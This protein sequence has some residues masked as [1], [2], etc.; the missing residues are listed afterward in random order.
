M[1][2]EKS[3]E[4][5]WRA[6]AHAQAFGETQIT[7]NTIDNALR[8]PGQYFDAET[9]LYQNYFRDYD[10][11]L[12]RYVQSDPTGLNGGLNY[13]SYVFANP[14]FFMDL[15]G[16]EVVGSWTVVP[17]MTQ[18]DF[19][20]ACVP[21]Y[22]QITCLA[23][24]SSGKLGWIG[25]QVSGEAFFSFGVECKDTCTNEEWEHS[26]NAQITASYNGMIPIPG[27]CGVLVKL[28]TGPVRS[29]W[30]KGRYADSMMWACRAAMA[31]HLHNG[32]KELKAVID[33]QIR[34]RGEDLVEHYLAEGPVKICMIGR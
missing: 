31:Y 26:S 7:L 32:W 12:G 2:F 11:R 27:M 8:F 17:H 15:L 23:P 9:G 20:F 13:Y 3:G 21:G 34:S 18:V 16:T 29:K 4:V 5:T 24:P 1:A 10:P 14:L 22:E 6:Q 30:A 19:T 28:V 25:I 33:K